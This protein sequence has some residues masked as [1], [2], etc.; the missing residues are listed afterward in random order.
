MQRAVVPILLAF[1][2][3]LPVSIAGEGG[4]EEISLTVWHSFAAE[5]QEEATF[6]DAVQIF[7][8]T[9]PHIL[10][11]VTG[12]PFADIDRQYE[13]AAQAGQAPDI[14][15][16]SSDQLGKIGEIRVNGFPLLEDLRPH[17]TPNQRST[18]DDQALHSMR[19]GDAL[20]GLPASQDCLSLLFNRALFDAEG[21][22]YPDENWTTQDL[23]S[24][25]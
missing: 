15:R 8:Q 5:S 1:L 18:F 16:L 23:I 14:V 2:L 20:Y 6:L 22:D 21:L 25:A 19:Y 24:A 7:E 3:L 4:E 9:H 10:V 12:I 17:L 11:E 13:I